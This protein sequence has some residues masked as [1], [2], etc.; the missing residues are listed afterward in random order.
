MAF[1]SKFWRTVLSI[2]HIKHESLLDF[3]MSFKAVLQNGF[4]FS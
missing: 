1:D 4:Y 2:K 3:Q